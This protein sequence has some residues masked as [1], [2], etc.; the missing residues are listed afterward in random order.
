MAKI[1]GNPAN[2]REEHYFIEEKQVGRGALNE[3]PLEKRVVM[4]SH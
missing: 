1:I 4:A 2:K 3:S